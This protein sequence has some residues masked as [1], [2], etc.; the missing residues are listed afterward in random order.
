EKEENLEDI[1][2]YTDKHRFRQIMQYFLNNA[3]KY[4]NEGEISFGYKKINV[5]GRK[6][7]KF[8]VKDTGIGIDQKYIS[9]IF[10]RFYKLDNNKEKLY[11]GTGLG[12]AI[13]KK[14]AEIIGGEI[15]VEST[16]D[17]G[18]TFFLTIPYQK[19]D[20][21]KVQINKKKES[22]DQINWSNKHILIVEDTPSNYIFIEAL[23]KITNASISWAKTG[24]EALDIIDEVKNIDLILMD[25][26][27]PEMNGYEI[28]KLI[29]MKNKN[30]PI[31]AQTAYAF[32]NER[33]NSI[34]A[35]CDDYISK[36]IKQN[37][38]FTTLS[39]YL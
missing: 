4:T 33:E 22:Y 20:K 11:R 18:S 31:I 24:K 8:F 5:G 30:I 35:G 38:F 17:V 1:A 6:L 2:I 28:T 15:E 16:I 10:N 23:L 7:L 14:L 9:N 3:F 19:L 26:Q 36:P 34:K 21:K 25:I 39:K 12:L 29:K 27:L 32:S 13:S 37:I